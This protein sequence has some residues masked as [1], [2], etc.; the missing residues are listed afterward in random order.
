MFDFEDIIL[1]RRAEHA[2]A[3]RA[4]AQ[5]VTSRW[6]GSPVAPGL[7]LPGNFSGF[8][9]T[10]SVESVPQSNAFM[11]GFLWFLILI[12][13]VAGAMIVFKGLLEGLS[14]M[15]LTR[16]DRLSFYRA[17]WFSYTGLAILRTVCGLSWFFS[18]P[19]DFTYVAH[20]WILCHGLPGSFSIYPSRFYRG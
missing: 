14:A 1:S 16:K 12:L 9:G 2:I 20:N 19:A 4:A 3:K 10:L 11:T 18:F 13:S 6:F 8:A 15:N 5:N 7:P 17:H